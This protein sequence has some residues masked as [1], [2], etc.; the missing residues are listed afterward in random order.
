LA[1]TTLVSVTALVVAHGAL[2]PI[3]PTAT[4]VLN[5][6]T[7]FGLGMIL[8]SLSVGSSSS[9]TAGTPFSPSRRFPEGCWLLALALFLVAGFEASRLGAWLYVLEGAAAVLIVLPAI[10]TGHSVRPPGGWVRTILAHRAVAWLGLV[11]Y[12]LYIWHAQLLHQ[13]RGVGERQSTL[14]SVSLTV[15]AWTLT[16]LC[17]TASFYLVE[18]PAMKAGRKQQRTGDASRPG[19]HRWRASRSQETRASGQS[20]QEDAP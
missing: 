7:W 4:A 13:L 18:L 1:A 3:S 17:A 2:G 15:V 9:G 14:T 12:G 5:G 8:A 11:S 19:H 20:A 10:T 6:A 16:L